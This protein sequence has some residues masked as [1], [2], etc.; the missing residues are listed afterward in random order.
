MNP[1]Q[2]CPLAHKSD[3][4]RYSNRTDGL[5]HFKNFL[6]IL[7]VIERILVFVKRP[8]GGVFRYL[9][10]AHDYDL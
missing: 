1:V 7:T 6:K 9:L 2:V 5:N 4:Q 10:V 3:R 8:K